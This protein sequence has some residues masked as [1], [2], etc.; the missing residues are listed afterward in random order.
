MLARI[1]LNKILSFSPTCV[2]QASFPSHG[3]LQIDQSIPSAG[4]GN[5]ISVLACLAGTH[6]GS[7]YDICDYLRLFRSILDYLSM[8]QVPAVTIPAQG[9]AVTPT[10]SPGLWYI[11]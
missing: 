5:T 4:A 2:S 10:S 7:E 3:A 9:Y 6:G 1:K 11:R 8:I